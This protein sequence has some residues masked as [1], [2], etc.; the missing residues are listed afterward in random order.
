MKR[1]ILTLAAI[2][3]PTFA[4]AQ[5]YED[6]AALL[7]DFYEPYFAAEYQYQDPGPFYSVGLS[8]LVERDRTEA[9]DGIGR[10]DFDPYIQGQDW[11]TESVDIGAVEQHGGTARVPVSFVNFD[12]ENQLEFS[13]VL[14]RDGWKIDDVAWQD[15]SSGE[16]DSLREILTVPLP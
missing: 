13:L 14:E 2:A 6:P 16:W 12:R 1:A 11:D 3:L 7:A 5:P 9:I 15:E 4:L 10:L 8:D